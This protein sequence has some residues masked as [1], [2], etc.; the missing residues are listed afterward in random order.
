MLSDN[1]TGVYSFC[2]HVFSSRANTTL[3]THTLL[4]TQDTVAIYIAT[5]A[6]IIYDVAEQL[7]TEDN[8]QKAQSL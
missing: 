2:H 1:G 7:L 4:Q 3:H 8:T 5:V 6:I